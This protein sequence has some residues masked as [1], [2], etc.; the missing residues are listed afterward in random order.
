MVQLLDVVRLRD[1]QIGTVVEMLSGGGLVIEIC[2]AQGRTIAL[3]VVTAG[4][5]AA[6]VWSSSQRES[7]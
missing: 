5:I 4:D 3:P 2:D 7:E 1:G 6:I